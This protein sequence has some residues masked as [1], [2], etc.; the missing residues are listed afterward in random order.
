[1]SMNNIPPSH[2][3]HTHSSSPSLSLFLALSLRQVAT[4]AV[5]DLEWVGAKGAMTVSARHREEPTHS[6]SGTA[7]DV[8]LPPRP[9]NGVEALQSLSPIGISAAG[10][11]GDRAGGMWES[12]PRPMLK[13]TPST[14]TLVGSKLG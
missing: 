14:V 12:S 11:S 7:S 2:T 9:A 4:E 13:I 6:R 3:P 8:R 1:M 10:V 5:P